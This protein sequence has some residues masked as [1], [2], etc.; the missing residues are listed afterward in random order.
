MNACL[1]FND[2]IEMILNAFKEKIFPL[3]PTEGG[4]YKILT[5]K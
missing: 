1:H 3:E 2:R 4:S 5:L